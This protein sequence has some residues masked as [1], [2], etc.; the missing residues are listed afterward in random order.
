MWRG[1][2][3]AINHR[4]APA[5]LPFQ[6]YPMTAFTLIHI[7]FLPKLYIDRIIRVQLNKIIGNAWH[8]G[9]KH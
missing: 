9:G 4:I 1:K 6:T 3:H 2:L 5:S 7:D 8:W